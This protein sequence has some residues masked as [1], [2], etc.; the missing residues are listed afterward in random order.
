MD[1]KTPQSVPDPLADESWEDLLG[2]LEYEEPPEEDTS[3]RG[4]AFGGFMEKVAQF[5]KRKPKQKARPRPSS[6][7]KPATEEKPTAS[8]SRRKSSGFTRQQKLILGGLGFLVLLVYAVILATV[9]KSIHAKPA[10][11]SGALSVVSPVGTPIN[12]TGHITPT[13]TVAFSV[14]VT[15]APDD[16]G[17]PPPPTLTPSPT[18]PQMDVPTQY[19]AQILES[20][21]D[22]S[23]RLKRGN[24][25]LRLQAYK[26]AEA[27][28]EYILTLDKQ[29]AEA[30]VGLG[31]VYLHTHRW[32]DAESAFGTAISFQENLS[33]AHF[34]LGY[35]YYLEG[36]YDE[37]AKEFDWAAELRYPDAALV[38]G[39]KPEK[40][41]AYVD[42]VTAESWL[43]IAAAHQ[44]QGEA[45]ME[46]ISR[47]VALSATQAVGTFP[48]VPIVYVGRSWAFR[49]QDP[50]AL[51]QAQGDLIYAKG[52]APYDFEV[53]NA[54]A[55]FYADNRPER[56]T[57]AEQLAQY[58][59]DWAKDDLQRA[60]ALHTMGLIYLAEDRK[61][62][63]QRVF[64]EAANLVTSDGKIAYAELAQD[65]EKAL[66]P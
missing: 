14:T 17:A 41:P 56:L 27:D 28:F 45:A 48:K 29:N 57:E 11:S 38:T 47:T 36:R 61:G 40:D 63:A 58:A 31:Q 59:L 60:R 55:R 13:A 3:Q 32:H 52:I 6:A 7:E 39:N 23:L 4:G 25:Y 2:A 5:R 10:P 66:A 34:N 44:G 24:E 49:A 50:P 64:S 15:P 20:P 16:E 37:A 19:D 62:D 18:P 33:S 35:E 22:I 12:W 53:L 30:Y 8:K 1:P 9:L 65:A 43:A 26:A 21:N 42:Y 54:L 51:D 46:A